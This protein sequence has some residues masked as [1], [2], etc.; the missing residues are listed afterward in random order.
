MLLLLRLLDLLWIDLQ[1]AL[2]DCEVALAIKPGYAEALAVRGSVK[3]M[4][5]NC[6][7]R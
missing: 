1:A 7:V 2:R 4:C 6:E 5:G 3:R